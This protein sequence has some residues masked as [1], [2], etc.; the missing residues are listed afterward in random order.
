MPFQLQKNYPQAFVSIVDPVGE[1]GVSTEGSKATYTLAGFVTPAATPTD[2]VNIQGS[3]TK[4]VRIK[5]VAIGVESTAAGI[6]D[7]QLVRRSAANT[8]GTSSSPTIG[9][10]ATLDGNATATVLVYTANPATLG[11]SAGV[12]GAAKLGMVTSGPI[13]PVTWEF[14]T[15]NDKPLTLS[16]TG[17]FLSVNGNGDTLLTG[18]VWAYEILWTEE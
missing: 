7:V 16:G 5:K 12:V 6:V 11:A 17:E 15:R 1:H 4:T 10:A 18:E 2:V 3:A 13:N 9:K 14:G 8:G